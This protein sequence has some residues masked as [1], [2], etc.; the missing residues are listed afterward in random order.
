M[1]EMYYISG[2]WPFSPLSSIAWRKSIKKLKE[3]WRV[4][5]N[6]MMYHI[7]IQSHHQLVS[8]LTQQNIYLS[9]YVFSIL[10]EKS[11]ESL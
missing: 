6:K 8:F 9:E 2:L 10:W 11:V 3:I 5:K 1:K 4:F 7:V